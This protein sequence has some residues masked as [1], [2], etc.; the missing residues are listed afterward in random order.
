MEGLPVRHLTIIEAAES[1]QLSVPT[2]KRYI[3]EGK[4]HSTKLPGGQHRISESEIERL[5]GSGA[6]ALKEPGAAEGAERVDL[7]ERWVT[8][9]QAEV[10]RLTAALEVVSR[11]CARKWEPAPAGGA[12]SGTGPVSG[13]VLLVLGPGCRRCDALHELTVE[14]LRA[15]GR[16]DA[17]VHRVES[18]D[19]IAAFGPVL[20]PA[21]ALG[22]EIIVSGR[23]PSAAALRDLLREHLGAAP[24]GDDGSEAHPP[25]G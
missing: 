8:D 10:E 23:A 17:A 16:A 21:L 18:L 1:L 15:L 2:V 11:F 22:G 24:G 25:R 7:L 5:L 13:P 4:L 9:L 3:Y 19:D 6:E 12:H 14:A 20:T